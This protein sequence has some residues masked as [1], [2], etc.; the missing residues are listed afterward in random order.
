MTTAKVSTAAKATRRATQSVKKI[1]KSASAAAKAVEQFAEA[2]N[3]EKVPQRK[4]K[5][6]AAAKK[7]R[8]RQSMKEKISDAIERAE[9]HSRSSEAIIKSTGQRCFDLPWLAATP[10]PWKDGYTRVMIP[11]DQPTKAGKR[12]LVQIVHNGK[13][14]HGAR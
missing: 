13:L 4:P 1:G 10:R 6:W 5:G 2:A 8:Q 11:L 3:V 7:E 14:S 9:S 12:F